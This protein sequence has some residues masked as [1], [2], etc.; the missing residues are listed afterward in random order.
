M[1]KKEVGKKKNILSLH[2]IILHRYFTGEY[3]ED[4]KLGNHATEFK[5]LGK[6][7]YKRSVLYHFCFVLAV[8]MRLRLNS[9][10]LQSFECISVIKAE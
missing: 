3:C 9:V 1:F 4:S 8:V 7:N 6:L 2:R 5:W 10:I